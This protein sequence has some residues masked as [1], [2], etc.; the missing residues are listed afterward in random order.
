LK[1]GT[2]NDRFAELNDGICKA[3]QRLGLG[4]QAQQ[5][6][7]RGQ[8]KKDQAA[9]YVALVKKQD[10]VI[11]LNQTLHKQI[12]QLQVQQMEQA[13]ILAEQM[14]SMKLQICFFDVRKTPQKLLWDPHF[15]V[16]YYELAPLIVNC[17][18]VLSVKF[19]WVNG[20]GKQS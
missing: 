19:M 20:V 12:Q 5:L 18:K 6:I 3:I 8:D 11:Q 10:E 9:D 7:D 14:A 15:T 13:T 17:Q 16:R 4:I 2:A 1:A